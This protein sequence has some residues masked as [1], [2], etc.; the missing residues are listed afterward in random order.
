MIVNTYINHLKETLNVYWWLP[1]ERGMCLEVGGEGKGQCSVLYSLSRFITVSVSMFV[2]AN[3]YVNVMLTS[4][5]L[6]FQ[7]LRSYNANLI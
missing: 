3:V 5:S 2:P 7:H 6:L 4:I 1:L